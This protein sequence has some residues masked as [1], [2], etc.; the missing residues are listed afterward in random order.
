MLAFSITHLHAEVNGGA[1]DG[2]GLTARPPLAGSD[3]TIVAGRASGIGACGLTAGSY[4][5]P[6]GGAGATIVGGAGVTTTVAGGGDTEAG[7]LP[8]SVA[9]N[10]VGGLYLLPLES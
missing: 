6:T 1:R 9:T 2:T 3:A 4:P 7:I 5:T 10:F 8:T